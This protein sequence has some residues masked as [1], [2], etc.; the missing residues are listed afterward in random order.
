MTAPEDRKRDD[1]APV[2]PEGQ[3]LADDLIGDDPEPEGGWRLFNDKGDRVDKS[4][5]VIEDEGSV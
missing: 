1:D 2:E 4:G 5:K 3:S